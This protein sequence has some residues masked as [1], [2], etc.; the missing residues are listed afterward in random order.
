MGGPALMPEMQTPG[1][2]PGLDLLPEPLDLGLL[3][4]LVLR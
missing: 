1:T 2:V 3:A 4:L